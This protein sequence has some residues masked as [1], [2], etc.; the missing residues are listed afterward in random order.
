MLE[1]NKKDLSQMELVS[2]EDFVPKD[3]LLRKINAAVDFDKIYEFVEDLYCHN[4][5]RPSIDP[6]ILFKMVL[7]QHL[8]GIPSLR[9]TAE[10]VKMKNCPSR[11]KCT[12]N[13]KYE[14]TVTKHIWLDYLETVEDIRYTDGMKELYDRRKETIERVFADAK[15]SPLRSV[16]N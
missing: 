12:E 16:K 11:Y 7:I 10:D 9:K 15:E 14:K 5:G 4:N 1:K 6:V 3:H 8:Y 13:S 2:V